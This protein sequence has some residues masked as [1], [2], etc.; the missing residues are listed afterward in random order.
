[1]VLETLLPNII[2]SKRIAV[3][4]PIIYDY[5][6][7]SLVVG[8]G[9]VVKPEPSFSIPEVVQ[10]FPLLLLLAPLMKELDL[11]WSNGTTLGGAVWRCSAELKHCG[12]NYAGKGSE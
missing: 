8:G 12:C 11:N 9:W 10:Q 2:F 1:M 6:K 3:D 5:D 4:S 7:D